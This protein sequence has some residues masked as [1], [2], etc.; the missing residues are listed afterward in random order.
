MSLLGLTR[1]VG[2]F[3]AVEFIVINAFKVM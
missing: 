3:M 1:V 2:G